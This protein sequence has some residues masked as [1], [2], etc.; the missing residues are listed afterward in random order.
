MQDPATISASVRQPCWF[1]G[2]ELGP[3]IDGPADITCPECG[4]RDTEFERAIRRDRRD[5]LNAAAAERW[6]RRWILIIAGYAFGTLVFVPEK[7]ALA[8]AALLLIVSVL[9]SLAPAYL[10]A[11]TG[12]RRDAELRRLLWQNSVWMLHL[13]WLLIAPYGALLLITSGL[14]VA[15]GGIPDLTVSTLVF[16]GTVIWLVSGLAAFAAWCARWTKSLN[17]LGTPPS[18]GLD[19]PA[20]L[21]GAVVLLGAGFVGLAGGGAAA[22][23]TM[24]LLEW[25]FPDAARR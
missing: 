18:T 15:C 10:V 6:S 3:L 9:L 24:N 5:W 19:W 25:A 23:G 22:Y 14:F 16:L 21:A 12:K 13:P 2:Y 20:T 4:H 7:E 8:V 17:L 1:C 11:A